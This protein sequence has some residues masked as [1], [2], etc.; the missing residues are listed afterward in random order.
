MLEACEMLELGGG[1]VKKEGGALPSV[2]RLCVPLKL[3]PK[4]LKTL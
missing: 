1:E 2:E 3:F 4:V